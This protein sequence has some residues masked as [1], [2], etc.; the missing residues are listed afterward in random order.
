MQ[1]N[2]GEKQEGQ[3]VQANRKGPIQQATSFCLSTMPGYSGQRL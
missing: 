2:T 1:E 3:G